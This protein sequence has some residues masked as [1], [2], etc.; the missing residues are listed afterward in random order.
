MRNN[1]GLEY[2]LVFV[3]D[4]RVYLVHRTRRKHAPCFADLCHDKLGVSDQR[5][6]S[7][8]EHNFV[9]DVHISISVLQCTRLALERV[10]SIC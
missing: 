4:P 10:H 2:L 5:Y 9:A 1:N 3:S 8:R 6:E 7:A